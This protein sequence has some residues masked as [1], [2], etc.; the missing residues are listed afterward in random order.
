MSKL[1]LNVAAVESD[2]DV[3]IKVGVQPYE[4]SILDSLREEHRGTYL[5]KRGGEDGNSILTVPRKAGLPPLGAS[6]TE[7]KLAEAPWI[8]APL[9][10]EALLEFFAQLQRPIL[11]SRPLRI[12]SRNP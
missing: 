2:P 8:L 9:V 11:R 12:V 10:M 6:T 4:K 7:H 1:T 3:T 5:V